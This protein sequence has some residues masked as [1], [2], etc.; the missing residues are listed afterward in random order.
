MVTVTQ[1][2]QLADR[3][4][5]AIGALKKERDSLRQQLEAL[6]ATFSEKEL[7]F[8]RI[9]KENQR[10]IEI[11]EREKLA[12]TREK[13]LIESQMDSL[14]DKLSAIMPEMQQT[15]PGFQGERSQ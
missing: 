8:I 7:E 9:P 2:E 14:Y 10:N 11:L 12:S 15:V 1:I 13:S 5:E 6:R 4:S 3:L